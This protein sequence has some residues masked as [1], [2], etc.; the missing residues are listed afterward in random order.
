MDDLLS[1][2][3]GVKLVREHEKQRKRLAICHDQKQKNR[4]VIFTSGG[5]KSPPGAESDIWSEEPARTNWKRRHTGG[6][7]G[8]W[9]MQLVS[10]Q[11]NLRKAHKGLPAG[12]NQGRRCRW[13]SLQ[14]Q[15]GG[16]C[17]ASGSWRHRWIPWQFSAFQKQGW[18]ASSQTKDAHVQE[19]RLVHLVEIYADDMMT[20]CFTQG[21]VH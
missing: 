11:A 14:C 13:S 10:N 3:S 17:N 2:G 19:P 1:F 20:R 7:V 9:E 4:S 16:A 15:P 12:P 5:I 18:R 8:K 6:G 21:T